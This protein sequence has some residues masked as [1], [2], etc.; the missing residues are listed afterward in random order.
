MANG[1]FVAT[2]PTGTANPITGIDF[3]QQ[4]TDPP[5]ISVPPTDYKCVESLKNILT[6]PKYLDFLMKVQSFFPYS[7]ET[8][9]SLCSETIASLSWLGAE[10][11]FTLNSKTYYMSGETYIAPNDPLP[12]QISTQ[13]GLFELEDNMPNPSNETTLVNKCADKDGLATNEQ[14]QQ[15]VKQL[16]TF[17]NS[18]IFSFADF[19]SYCTSDV[20]DKDKL[21]SRSAELKSSVSVK[22]LDRNYL[23]QA[24]IQLKQDNSIDNIDASITAKDSNIPIPL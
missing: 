17:Y 22:G 21:V 20:M 24:F 10:A 4:P 16:Y 15:L 18:T 23:F 9:D 7:Y 8:V 12:L 1:Q 14:L 6:S 5:Q 13:M 19:T 11:S 2:I 3:S